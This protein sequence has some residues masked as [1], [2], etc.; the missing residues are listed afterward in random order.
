MKEQQHSER[1]DVPF[2]ID[3]IQN[4]IEAHWISATEAV[5]NEM[6]PSVTRLHIHLPNQQRVV[7]D[8]HDQR[9][10]LTEYFKMNTIDLD[11]RNLIYIEFPMYYTWNKAIKKWKKKATWWLYWKIVYGSS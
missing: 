2:I 9:T 7:F 6:H 10:T 1:N 3:E 8:E 11:A 4:F 5:W